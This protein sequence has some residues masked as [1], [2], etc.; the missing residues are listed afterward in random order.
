VAVYESSLKRVRYHYDDHLVIGGN[1]R[2]WIDD[3]GDLGASV[4]TVGPASL[5]SL[6]GSLALVMRDREGE[7]D[8]VVLW[9]SP[10]APADFDDETSP[11]AQTAIVWRDNELFIRI[12]VPVPK[13]DD[14]EWL[15]PLIT[16]LAAAHRASIDSIH[17]QT[18]ADGPEVEIR[19]AFELAR[20]SVYDAVAFGQ[21][22]ALLI[23]LA[24]RREIDSDG[25]FGLL[26]LGAWDALI[27]RCENDWLEAKR[28]H[29]E[30]GSASG[31]LELAKD[32]ASLANAEGSLI[33][34]GCKTKSTPGG[35]VVTSINRCPIDAR[36]VRSYRRTVA[37]LVTPPIRGLQIEALATETAP[38]QGLLVVRIPNQQRED[39]PFIV[40][41]IQR[42]K[43][44]HSAY[45]G[46]PHRSGEDTSWISVGSIQ[47]ALRRGLR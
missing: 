13:A 12:R 10:D 27:G 1:E 20:R 46:I 2:V 9:L 37:R 3:F 35:D 17:I 23:E 21:P 22:M 41:G 39:G 31:D 30:L 7:L 32:V 6:R 47:A 15:R 42:G 24:A 19:C 45:V 11:S 26:A 34:I 18:T 29:S 16:P 36:T 44:I 14:L 38:A 40:A 33:V 28:A 4:E 5:T 8:E 25:M 43:R